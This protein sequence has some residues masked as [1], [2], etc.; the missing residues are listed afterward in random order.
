MTKIEISNAPK[1][2]EFRTNV[3]PCNLSS[4]TCCNPWYL[5]LLG[6]EVTYHSLEELYFINN[7]V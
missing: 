6:F 4:T 3:N 5:A 1:D 2:K 7:V